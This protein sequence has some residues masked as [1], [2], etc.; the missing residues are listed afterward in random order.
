MKSVRVTYTVQAA[1]AAENQENIKAFLK[2]LQQDDEIRYHVFVGEDGKT[3]YHQS[4]YTN[5]AAQ[6]RLL[7]LPSFKVF[8]QQRDASGLESAPTIENIVHVASSHP[9]I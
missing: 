9:I 7:A 5:D 4:T 3:F 6:T 2:D 8:Q 1:F